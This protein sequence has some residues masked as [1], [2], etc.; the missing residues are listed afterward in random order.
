[1]G[2]GETLAALIN[3]EKVTLSAGVP[4][5]WLGLLAHLKKSGQRIDSLERIIVGGAAC[6]LSI[7]EDLDSYG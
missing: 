2:D 3:E 7:M 6:P 5:V 1:M 4:T